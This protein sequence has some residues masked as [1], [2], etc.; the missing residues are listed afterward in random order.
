MGAMRRTWRNHP[1]VQF[2]EP[3]RRFLKFTNRSFRAFLRYSR[4]VS[5]NI[6]ALWA[7]FA[8][9]WLEAESTGANDRQLASSNPIAAQVKAHIRSVYD[10]IIAALAPV[11]EINKAFW[12][13]MEN[14]WKATIPAPIQQFFEAGKANYKVFKDLVRNSKD[15]MAWV[16]RFIPRARQLTTKPRNLL[17]SA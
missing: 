17:S 4:R 13:N 9:R 8:P 5:L 6:Q 10:I 7:P 12:K 3:L 1:V 2:F 15:L 14:F 11:R 16:E